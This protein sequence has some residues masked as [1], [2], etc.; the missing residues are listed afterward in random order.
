MLIVIA[1]MKKWSDQMAPMLP[2]PSHNSSRAVFINGFTPDAVKILAAAAEKIPDGVQWGIGTFPVFGE[3]TKP[4]PESSFR[5]REPFGFIHALGPV[6]DPSR[7][8][9]GKEWTDGI[10]NELKAAGLVKANYLGILGLDLDVEECFG[11]ENFGR[12]K[13]LKRK[14]DP[15]NV[16][17]HVP[18]AL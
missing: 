16:F 12:L 17:K 10:L 13:A 15:E 4:H 14:V 18:A 3:S 5:V 11:K 7:V 6:A 8:A 2:P 1:T 9:E